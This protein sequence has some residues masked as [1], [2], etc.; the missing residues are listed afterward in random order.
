LDSSVEVNGLDDAEPG[1]GAADDVASR[2]D[3]LAGAFEGVVALRRVA[4]VF[5]A[6][7]FVAALFVVADFFAA[8]R[9]AGAVF[10]AAAFFFAGDFPAAFL[11]VDLA[12][13][14]AGDFVA[15]EARLAGADFALELEELDF[16]A[17]AMGAPS[18][19]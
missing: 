16:C 2:P 18:G 9:L 1:L 7:D 6:A 15:D 8:G 4:A 17:A 13:D 3:P 19:W 5:F 12:V 11:A 10:L 14:L